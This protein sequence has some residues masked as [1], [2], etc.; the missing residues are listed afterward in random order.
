M[1]FNI[2]SISEIAIEFTYHHIVSKFDFNFNVRL[3]EGFLF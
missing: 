2:C 3:S 1:E